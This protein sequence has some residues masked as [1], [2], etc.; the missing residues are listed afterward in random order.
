[1]PKTILKNTSLSLLLL[2]PILAVFG[3]CL[4][5]EDRPTYID[6]YSGWYYYDSGYYDDDWFSGPEATCDE[7]SSCE[8]CIECSLDGPTCSTKWDR[9]VNSAFCQ[10]YGSCI[11]DCLDFSGQAQ[12][13]CFDQCETRYG[14]GASLWF[15]IYFCVHCD[16]CPTA[17]NV[18][19]MNQCP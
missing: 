1:M 4:A 7:S 11:N 10:D 16:A 17:C 14:S 5:L 6:T 12:E 18:F 2:L 3:S 15:D 13:N 9:C 19:P 8:S